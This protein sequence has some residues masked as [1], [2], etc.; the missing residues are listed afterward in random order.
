MILDKE[1]VKIAKQTF[2]FCIWTLL[3]IYTEPS[4]LAVIFFGG[5]AFV[6]WIFLLIN[7]KNQISEET[8]ENM[9]REQIISTVEK[10]TKD[11]HSK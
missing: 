5:I 2:A 9:T 6:A 4:I 8:K 7:F 10:I 3:M 11:T 1:L